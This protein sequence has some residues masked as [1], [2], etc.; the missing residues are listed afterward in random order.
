MDPDLL[1][2]FIQ[3]I[4]DDIRTSLKRIVLCFNA[5]TLIFVIAIPRMG[6]SS[7]A[8]YQTQADAAIGAAPAKAKELMRSGIS[9]GLP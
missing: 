1:Q 4:R 6:E 7:G 8:R 5:C 9:S 3:E 2:A